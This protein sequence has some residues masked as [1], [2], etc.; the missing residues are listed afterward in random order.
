MLVASVRMRCN[1]EALVVWSVC[2]D[3]RNMSANMHILNVVVADFDC[4]IEQARF[5]FQQLISGVSYCHAMVCEE[6]TYGIIIVDQCHCFV[7]SCSTSIDNSS[8][9]VPL[10]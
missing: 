1:F 2:I 10:G 4:F 9:K 8:L 3:F 7:F 5:F 6:Q